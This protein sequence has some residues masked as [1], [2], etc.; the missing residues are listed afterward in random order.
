MSLK[1]A[2]KK[3]INKKLGI[4]EYFGVAFDVFGGLLKEKTVIMISV[5]VFMLFYAV[6]ET[7][8]V[9][10]EKSLNYYQINGMEINETTV[11]LFEIINI[12]SL[13]TSIILFF[14][15]AYFFRKIALAIE[16]KE[17]DPKLM[18][19]F[20]K[21]LIIFL[22]LNA[23]VFIINNMAESVIGEI[24]L[25]LFFIVIISISIWGLW[26]YEAYYIRNF[27]ILESF[28]Y[29]LELS[30]GNRLRKFFSGLIFSIGVLVFIL[31]TTKIFDILNIKNLTVIIIIAFVFLSA[32]VLV[33][34]YGQI[35]NIVIFLNVEYDY[36]GKNLNEELEFEND[37][38]L[39]EDNQVLNT[40]LSNSKND[41]K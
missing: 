14:I 16:E 28:N 2:R 3:L 40:F 12:L 29:S 20:V 18:K 27:G 26:Y 11:L 22:I 15:T 5:F 24:F 6:I 17:N 1:D 34:M 39:G 33:V 35:L 32:I 13:G 41:E 8:G 38:K 19:F 9:V 31:I 23:A 37:N 4:F 36:L 10:L 25:I 30:D 7:I 21:T